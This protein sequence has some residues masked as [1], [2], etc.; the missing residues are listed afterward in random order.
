MKILFMLSLLMSG[1][2]LGE[3][4][5]SNDYGDVEITNLSSGFVIKTICYD[6]NGRPSSLLKRLSLD[7]SRSCKG[8]YIKVKFIGSKKPH[9]R[10]YRVYRDGTGNGAYSHDGSNG[11]CEEKKLFVEAGGS[12]SDPYVT[13]RCE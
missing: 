13:S 5:N 4:E 11:L 7:E 6:I 10:V 9:Y 8:Y 12:L 2:A 3:E 1:V